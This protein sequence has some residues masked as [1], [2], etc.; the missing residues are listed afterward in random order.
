MQTKFHWDILDEH[1]KNLLP[2]LA[3]LKEEGF[4]L[5]GGTGLALQIGHRRSLDFDFYKKDAFSPNDLQN[6]IVSKFGADKVKTANMTKNF[7]GLLINNIEVSFFLYPYNLVKN[8]IGADF[9][10]VASITDIGAMKLIA[11]VQRGTKRDF[12]DIYFLIT[13]LGLKTLLKAV[14]VKYPGYNIYVGLQALLYFTDA[15]KSDEYKNRLDPIAK[16]DWS[17]IKKF[18]AKEV[19]KVQKSL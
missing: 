8:L 16:F 14:Q 17:K 15:E 4:Y 12:V 2:K 9:G 1:R 11:I 13:Q 10:Y 6:M 19:F 18:I 3:F 7:A 5:A